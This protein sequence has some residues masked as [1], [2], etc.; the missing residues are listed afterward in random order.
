VLCEGGPHLFGA[1]AAAGVVDEVYLT[2]SPLLAGA[3][4]GRIIAG[5]TGPAKV[6]G[7][8]RDASGEPVPLPRRLA[9]GHVLAS[10]DVLLLRY[11]SSP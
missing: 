4:A 11:L 7:S 10:G 9:L 3:G 8:G 6:Q 5:P 2:L 1:L